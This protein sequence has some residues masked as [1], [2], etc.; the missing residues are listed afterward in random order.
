MH[1]LHL[2]KVKSFNYSEIKIPNY[3]VE[4]YKNLIEEYE[5]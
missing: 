3:I 1:T 5:F 4:K 2:G